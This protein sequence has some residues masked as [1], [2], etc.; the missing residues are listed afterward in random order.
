M[1]P[2]QYTAASYAMYAPEGAKVKPVGEW[3]S[4][5]IIVNYPHVQHWLNGVK[6]ADYEFGSQDWK[7][8]KAPGRWAD[9][10]HFGIEKS[11]HIGLQNAGKAVYRNIKISKL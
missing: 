3:N 6:V 4:T 1:K 8:R 7:A 5:R 10:P 2:N 11:G 9:V